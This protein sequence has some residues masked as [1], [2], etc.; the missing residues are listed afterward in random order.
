[1]KGQLTLGQLVAAELIVTS[2]VAGLTKF[3]KYLESFYDLVASI[4]KLGAIDDLEAERDDGAPRRPGEGPASLSLEDLSFSVGTGRDV[5]QGVSLTVAAGEHVAV[6]GGDASGKTTLV[7]LI[8]GMRTPSSGR[9]VLDGLDIRT[10]AV[11][12]LRKD[13]AIAGHPELFDG[14][15]IENVCMGRTGL[16]A[17]DV[18]LAVEI[19]GLEEDAARLDDGLATQLGHAGRAL[20]ASQAA[21]LMIARAVLARPRLLVIDEVLDGLDDATV[22][23]VIERLEHN[24]PFASLLVFTSRREIARKFGRIARLDAGRM[25]SDAQV[26]S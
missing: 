16:H 19:A 26:V 3:G 24:V 21:R 2:V 12:E 4:D 17:E 11:G 25:T 22:A 10:L 18:A 14:T 20:T 15:L 5:V 7:D 23:R 8:Y 6:L 1:M 9:V 13:I